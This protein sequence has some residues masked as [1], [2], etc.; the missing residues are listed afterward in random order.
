MKTARW[1]GI[2]Y[3]AFLLWLLLFPPWMELREA[4]PTD[5]IEA[6]RTIPAVYHSLGHHWRFSVLLHQAYAWSQDT[7][8]WGSFVVP[9]LKARIDYQLMFYEAAIGLVA[10]SLLYLLL[11]ALEMPT[12]IGNWRNR[13]FKSTMTGVR[14]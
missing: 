12:R 2:L 14:K 5:G 13:E 1:Y 11:P 7:H 9:N 6:E 8:A 4:L 10:L 3:L